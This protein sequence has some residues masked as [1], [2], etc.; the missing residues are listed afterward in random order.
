MKPL[1]NESYYWKLSHLDQCL[2]FFIQFISKRPDRL[3]L[4]HQHIRNFFK[5]QQ[6]RLSEKTYE[7][8]NRLPSKAPSKKKNKFEMAGNP[9][10]KLPPHDTHKLFTRT[11]QCPHLMKIFAGTQRNCFLKPYQNKPFNTSH[12]PQLTEDWKTQWFQLTQETQLWSI[13]SSS[14]RRFP[15]FWSGRGR[16]YDFWPDPSLKQWKWLKTMFI[17]TT[18]QWNILIH[19][20]RSNNSWPS[21]KKTVD[22]TRPCHSSPSNQSPASSSTTGETFAA[23]PV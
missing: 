23:R 12:W 6:F 10:I 19:M 5:L 17:T 18:S 22:G 11:D 8:L 3:L 16:A 21:G 9:S 20:M 13:L 1:K 4:L 14:G 2:W 7:Q 15:P